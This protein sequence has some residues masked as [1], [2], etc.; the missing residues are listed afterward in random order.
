MYTAGDIAMSWCS[1]NSTGI[2]DIFVDDYGELLYLDGATD[3]ITVSENAT[4]TLKGGYI[5]AITSMQVVNNNPH[6]D[7]Y[8]QPGWSWVY[9]SSNIKGITGLWENDDPFNISFIDDDVY[10]PVWENI[11]VV[12]IPEP[13]TLALLSLG[14]LLIRRKKQQPE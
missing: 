2:W 5:D 4:A 14:G 1:T 13:A 3:E 12:E 10:D 7:L 11:N 9:Q 6:I 8:C